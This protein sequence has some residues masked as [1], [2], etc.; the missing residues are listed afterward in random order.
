MDR[1]KKLCIWEISSQ[2]NELCRMCNIRNRTNPELEKFEDMD[3]V[4]HAIR[5][6]KKQ[7]VTDVYIQGGEPVIHKRIRKI[8]ELLADQ[9][10]HVRMITNGVLLEEDFVDFLI[11]MGIGL[12]I[13]LDTLNAGVYQTI[14]GKD[15]LS[16][17][18]AN[19]KMLRQKD[20]TSLYWGIHSVITGQ[21]VDEV[22]S[23]KKFAKELRMLHSAFPLISSVGNAGISNS[24]LKNED[25][26]VL[27]ILKCLYS[28]EKDKVTKEEYRIAAKCAEGVM[29]G[30]CD[31]FVY[32]FVLDELGNVK[33]CIEKEAVYNIFEQDIDELYVYGSGY[34][35][36]ECYHRC[37]YGGTRTYGIMGRMGAS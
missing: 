20:F 4:R 32:S 3:H 29:D 37:F 26:K 24:M 9:G 11:R 15:M 21:N 6:M 5:F 35:E 23:I 28:Q 36:C 7:M 19:L 34:D 25:K 10:F 13:S 1:L 18:L 33:P 12:T 8:L 2:C 14:R 27:R 31:A 17:V 16:Q 30:R 22:M